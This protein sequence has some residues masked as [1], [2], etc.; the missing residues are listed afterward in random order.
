MSTLAERYGSRKVTMVGAVIASVG[1]ILSTQARSNEML[2]ATFGVI[3]GESDC[4]VHC[5]YISE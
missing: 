2:I 1:F 4:I 5:L 3:G